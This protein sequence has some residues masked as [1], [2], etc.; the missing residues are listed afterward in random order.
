MKLLSRD[1]LIG[2]TDATLF[3]P[4]LS[5]AIITL[6]ILRVTSDS[7]WFWTNANISDSIISN[8]SNSINIEKD[9]VCSSDPT[10]RRTSAPLA[11][12][13]Y[14]HLPSPPETKPKYPSMCTMLGIRRMTV[15]N[16]A[17]ALK[18]NDKK[19]RKEGCV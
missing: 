9:A 16:E 1:P 8:G 15:G 5:R 12:R 13:Q 19:P 4:E 18:L 3:F 17:A 14:Q 10:Y 7:S 11:L 6:G 2:T